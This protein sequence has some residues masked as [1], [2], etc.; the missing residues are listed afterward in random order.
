MSSTSSRL[1]I[2]TSFVVVLVVAPRAASA[3]WY[4]GGYL[5]GNYT[6]P[7]DV[8]VDTPL[9]GVSVTAEDVEFTAEPLRSPQYYGYRIGRWVGNSNFAIELEFIHLKVI[10]QTQRSY[11]L[12]GTVDGE[13]VS[14]VGPFDA[15][16]ERYAMTHGLNFAVINL[17][18]RRPLSDRLGLVLRGGAGATI[19]HAE[20]TIRGVA[21]ELYELAGPGVHGA[22]GVDV[23]LAGRTSIFV[24]Y[25]ATWAEPEISIAGGTG[26]T[27]SVSQH[28]AIGFALGIAR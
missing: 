7:A 23:R 25:K 2:L 9:L 6:H 27:T 15:L 22:A 11:R 28:V 8:R 10:G 20:T 4:V 1:L 14:A 24:E 19:P 3:Q 12:T 13:A 26:R 17:M 16:V 5:G 18:Y 21:R